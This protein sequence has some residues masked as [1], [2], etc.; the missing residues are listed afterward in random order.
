[1][2][3]QKVARAIHFL[4]AVKHWDGNICS[5]KPEKKEKKSSRL[6]GIQMIIWKVQA[7]QQTEFPLKSCWNKEWKSTVLSCIR[8]KKMNFR[9]L[10]Q[11]RELSMKMQEKGETDELKSLNL[12]I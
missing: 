3:V 11:L 4:S 8:V 12:T 6:F 7:K 1:M 10:P 2:I 9:F 5:Q